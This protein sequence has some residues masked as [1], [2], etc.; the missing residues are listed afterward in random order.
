MKE[1]V[2]ETEGERV[3]ERERGRS[4]ERKDLTTA[5][6]ILTRGEETDQ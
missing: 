2:R 5:L 3:R 1:K 4:C 6:D